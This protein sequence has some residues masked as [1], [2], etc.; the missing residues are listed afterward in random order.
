[1]V[2]PM[3]LTIMEEFLLLEDRPSC[4]NLMFF[5]TVFSGQVDRH[6]FDAALKRAVGRHPF[7]RAI[8][9]QNTAGR[10]EW[11]EVTQAQP[12][13]IW[14][15]VPATEVLP[16]L[17]WLNLRREVGLRVRVTIDAAVNTSTILFQIHHSVCDGIGADTFIGDFL[18]AYALEMGAAADLAKFAELNEGTLSERG[19]FELTFAKFLKRRLMVALRRVCSFPMHQPCPLIPYGARPSYSTLLGGHPGLL[20]HHFHR[21]EASKLKDVAKASGVTLNDLLICDLFLAVQRWQREQGLNN[22]NE[23]LRIMI[24]MNLRQRMHALLPACNVVSSIFINRRGNA[25]DQPDRLLRSIH[26]EMQMIK[27][28]NLGLTFVFSLQVRRCLPGGWRR[29]RAARKCAVSTIL[30]NLGRAFPRVSLPR[31]GGHLVAGNLC[32]EQFEAY[33]PIQPY[34]D[35]AFG[36]GLYAERLYTTMHFDPAVIDAK[37]A[38]KLLSAFV[39]QIRATARCS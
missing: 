4:P 29:L 3:P 34:T 28:N 10:W 36:I 30:S 1:M 32:L 14:G 33:V 8:V 23:W 6:A 11:V 17:T 2:F 19:R 27:D 20:A 37:A 5:R 7:F 38:D 31:Q 22:S 24:P 25:G 21:E 15:A 18:V 39:N 12:D 16:P 9:K 35:A 26:D 13:V